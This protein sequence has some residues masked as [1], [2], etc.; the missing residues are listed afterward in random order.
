MDT[1][2]NLID[3]LSIVNIRIWFA[4]DIKRNKEATDRQLA[5]ACRI[6]NVANSQRNDLIQEIDEMLN[7]M[8]TTGELQKLYKQGATKLYGRDLTSSE[9]V[10]DDEGLVAEDKPS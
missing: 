7:K 4:E 9:S 6:T 10:Q 2:G 8:V 3:K 1:I 5:D